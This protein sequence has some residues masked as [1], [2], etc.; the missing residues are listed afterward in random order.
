MTM[1]FV[2]PLPATAEKTYADYTADAPPGWTRKTENLLAEGANVINR[3]RME[4]RLKGATGN[5]GEAQITTLS[6]KRPVA[7]AEAIQNEL[8]VVRQIGKLGE[9]VRVAPLTSQDGRSVRIYVFPKGVGD[10]YQRLG[11]V[12]LP[13][14][15]AVIH[16]VAPSGAGRQAG[17]PAFNYVVGSF[18]YV[19]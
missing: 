4:F 17:N 16:L 14:G 19:P 7:F 13:G 5:R 10:G 3:R 11:F 2:P 6:H 8:S 9:P 18:R 1:L 15:Y 12:R